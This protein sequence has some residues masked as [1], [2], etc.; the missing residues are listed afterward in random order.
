M[1]A[2][3]LTEFLGRYMYSLLVAIKR[4]EIG[5]VRGLAWTQVGGDTL[6]IEVN[7]MPGSGKL[8]ISG[9]LGDVMKESA[10]IAMSLMRSLLPKQD[11]FV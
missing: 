6:E 4:P 10:Q 2:R 7:T 8:I 5:I 11:K 9:I 1:T 3:N